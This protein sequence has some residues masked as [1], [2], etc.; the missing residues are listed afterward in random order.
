MKNRVKELSR[1][2]LEA[3]RFLAKTGKPDLALAILLTTHEM[4]TLMHMVESFNET[5]KTH[6]VLSAN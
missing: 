4:I 6:E 3:S 2:S 5:R 1:K